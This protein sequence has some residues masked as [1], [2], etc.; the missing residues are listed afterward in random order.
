MILA[1]ANFWAEAIFQVSALQGSL[2]DLTLYSFA[3]L[4]FISNTT[5]CSMSKRAGMEEHRLRLPHF[6]YME[7]TNNVESKA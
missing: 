3:A 4:W 7:S 5:L 1:K 6:A 2:N